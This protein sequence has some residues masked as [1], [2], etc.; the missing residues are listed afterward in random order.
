MTFRSEDPDIYIDGLRVLNVPGSNATTAQIPLQ[1]TVPIPIR[2][3]RTGIG[4][5]LT[6]GTRWAIVT[7]VFLVGTCTGGALASSA[8]P[9]QDWQP[10][11]TVIQPTTVV[12]S[13]LVQTQQVPVP[14]S[15]LK[16]ILQ[17][18]AV[19]K[20]A[21]AVADSGDRE[22]DII[23]QAYQGVLAKDGKKLND[24]AGE[25]RELQL[26]LAKSQAEVILP[27]QQLMDGLATCPR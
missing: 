4:H 27:Y 8:T 3:K 7:G 23:S 15:C 2:A 24:A 9:K 5:G 1:D 13:P 12:V 16:A 6:R 25:Q 20:A 21:T 26:E 22:L 10:Q 18:E 19:L 14:A 11:T 17:A